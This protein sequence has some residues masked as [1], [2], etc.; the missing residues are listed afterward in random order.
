MHGLLL[1]ND[2]NGAY[3]NTVDDAQCG[4][5]PGRGTAHAAMTASLFTDHCSVKGLSSVQ[6]FVDLAQAFD[7]ICRQLSL[8]PLG[9]RAVQLE[10][11][12]VALGLPAPLRARIMAD[13]EVGRCLLTEAGASPSLAAMVADV[14]TPTWFSVG[15][16]EEYSHSYRDSAWQCP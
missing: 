12:L 16:T 3:A 2:I 10:A 9:A 14:H 7:R 1:K 6:L 4:C 8:G 15:D 13:A 5:V 11:E